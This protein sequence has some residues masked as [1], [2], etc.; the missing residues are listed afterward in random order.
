MNI[1]KDFYFHILPNKIKKNEAIY[2]NLTNLTDV[3]ILCKY[4][5]PKNPD[6]D[7]H[8]FINNLYS[9]DEIIALKEIKTMF[10]FYQINELSKNN[11]D[12]YIVDKIRLN[13]L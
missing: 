1:K 5:F 9:K 3:Y 4:S 12:F 10:S 13:K 8:K 6:F 2:E 7:V 11:I